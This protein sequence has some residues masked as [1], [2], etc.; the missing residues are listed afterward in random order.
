MTSQILKNRFRSSTSKRSWKS[1]K[2]VA[3]RLGWKGPLLRKLGNLRAKIQPSTSR[4]TSR[5][6]THQGQKR[7]SSMETFH[8]EWPNS[9]TPTKLET[10]SQIA[11][12]RQ[13]IQKLG[14]WKMCKWKSVPFKRICLNFWVL[15]IL[16]LS[17]Q[18]VLAMGWVAPIWT[19][20]I[21]LM[22][23]W[24]PDWSKESLTRLIPKTL[25]K[26]NRLCWWSLK[27][28]MRSTSF[29]QSKKSRRENMMKTLRKRKSLLLQRESD[30]LVKEWLKFQTLKLK[31][32]LESLRKIP[33][34][35]WW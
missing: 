27:S 35:I 12:Q 9:S 6:Q 23:M 25:T 26:M 24:Q 29:C 21:C 7:C 14:L 30:Y 18:K 10:N 17:I 16:W 34:V 33:W 15:T 22:K 31:M 11:T 28:R 4:I 8:G 19:S 1:Y 2:D 20:I 13:E 5:S 3:C 32:F